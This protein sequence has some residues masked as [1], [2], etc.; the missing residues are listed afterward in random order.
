ML[1][2]LKLAMWNGEEE[3]QQQK[4]KQKQKKE[5]KRFLKYMSIYYFVKEKSSI[6]QSVQL[7][8][9]SLIWKAFSCLP[10]IRK[11]IKT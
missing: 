5:K 10:T 3:E 2:K 9:W 4:T 6:P 8:Q 1:T 7:Q 11:T